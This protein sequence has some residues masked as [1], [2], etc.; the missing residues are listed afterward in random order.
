LPPWILGPLISTP[1]TQP[2]RQ[3]ISPLFAVNDPPVIVK[4]L[5][6]L[7]VRLLAVIPDAVKVT[8]PEPDGDDEE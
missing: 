8:D 6:A 3:T 4:S 1:G 7:M 5:A 2:A